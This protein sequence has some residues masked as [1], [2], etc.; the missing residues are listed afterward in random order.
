MSK[1][2]AVAT[3]VR[4]DDI[5]NDIVIIDQVAGPWRDVHTLGLR[6]AQEALSDIMG[7]GHNIH[8]ASDI[9]TNLAPDECPPGAKH[10]HS[11]TVVIFRGYIGNEII[12]AYR[13]SIKLAPGTRISH[14]N[15]HRLRSSP[16]KRKIH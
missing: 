1:L 11:G 10:E 14:G 9:R 3:V 5:E 12:Q 7:Q 2:F 16:K 8:L 6:A 4:M 15:A 13:T